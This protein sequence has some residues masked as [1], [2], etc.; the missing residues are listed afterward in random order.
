MKNNRTLIISLIAIVALFIG[1][2]IFVPQL[3]KTSGESGQISAPDLSKYNL[4]GLIAATEDNG[5][6][7]DHVKGDIT[8]AEVVL[9]EYADYQCTACATFNPWIKELIK[10]YD[11]KLAIVFRLYPITSLHPNGIAA[12]SAVD[13]AGLHGY[14]EEMGDLLFANQAEWYYSTGSNRTNYFIS[15]FQSASKGEGDVAKFKEDMAG[16]TVKSKVN[17]DKAIAEKLGLTYTPA[18]LDSDGNELDFT[19]DDTEQTKSGIMN[20]FRSHI[21]AKLSK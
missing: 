5:N 6:I 9:Y 10:E 16:N 12:A 14:W 2:V 17:F 21:D 11:G 4:N 1:A 20:F 7:A 18:F 15:Y 8:T 19:K 3:A 13:A